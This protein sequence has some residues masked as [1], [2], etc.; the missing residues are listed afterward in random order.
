MGQNTK[1]KRKTEIFLD[2]RGF[3]DSDQDSKNGRNI[4]VFY[5]M[6]GSVGQSM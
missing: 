3:T 5:R 2:I 4:D 6:Y 1:M